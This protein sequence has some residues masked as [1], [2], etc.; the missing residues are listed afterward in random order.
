VLAGVE[1]VI[2]PMARGIAVP[3][4][5]L[6]AAIEFFDAFVVHC[7]EAKEE[8]ALFPLLERRGVPPETLAALRGQHAEGQRILALL[9]ASAAARHVDVDAA[10]LCEQ[11]VQLERSHLA[12]EGATFITLAEPVLSNDDDPALCAAFDAIE[13]AVGGTDGADV[14]LRLGR[15]LTD[16][17]RSF[18]GNPRSRATLARDLVRRPAVVTPADTLARAKNLMDSLGTREVAVVEHG[19]LIGLVTRSDLEPHRG[20]L[21]WTTVRAAMTPNPI[22]VAPET[23]ASSVAHLLVERGFNAVPVTSGGN[24]LG[25][26]CRSDLLALLDEPPGGRPVQTA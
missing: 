1:S 24:L 16:A 18:A 10:R 2:A 11:Y 4:V 6:A 22:T 21:E 15:A 23:P 8:Q 9:R 12:L 26:I 17:C 5:L 7:H 20:H 25:M 14:L 3:G 19:T 13:R